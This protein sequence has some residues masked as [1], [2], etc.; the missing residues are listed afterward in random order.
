MRELLDAE[1][2]VVGGGRK[3][4]KVFIKDVNANVA[5]VDQDASLSVGD[6]LVIKAKKGSTVTITVSN[7]STIDQNIT[8]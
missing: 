2:D 8:D 7:T 6:D 3:K 4:L 5:V 1:L